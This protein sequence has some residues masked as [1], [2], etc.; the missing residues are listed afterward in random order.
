MTRYNFEFIKK[1]SE[2]DEFAEASLGEIKVLVA[3]FESGGSITEEELVSAVG[4]SKSRT[5]AALALWQ[6]AGVIREREEGSEVS[7]FGN[8]VTEEFADRGSDDLVEETAK[9]VAKTIRDNKLAS[10]F[11]E[12]AKMMNKLMLTPQE[13]RR[14]SE[15]SSQYALSEEYILTLAAHLLEE[16]NLSVGILVKRAITLA[17]EGIVSI[18]ALSDYISEKEARKSEFT[19]YRRIFGIYNRSF[20]AK[21]KE[22]LLRWSKEF[23]YGTEVVGMA[24]DITVMNTSKLSF[25]Y[26]DK[27]LTD[28]HDNGCLT[29]QQCEK[30]Y[31]ER[32]A[33]LDKAA[34]EEKEKNAKRRPDKKDKPA[35]RYGDFDPEE[36]FKLALARSYSSD[37]D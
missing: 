25:K 15:L 21:E 14:I 19:E 37:E 32:K 5:V 6:E 26:M 10:L 30:R 9:E 35:K 36:A 23:S 7:F 34:E 11:D 24:Y 20:S 2:S 12:C 1:P 13:I 29:L 16:G 27:L 17:G 31:I 4:A 3:L 8:K 18:E 22:L 33:E 28:W